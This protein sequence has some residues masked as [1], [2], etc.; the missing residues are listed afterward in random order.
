MRVSEET[1]YAGSRGDHIA[2]W[3]RV[4]LALTSRR[5]GLIARSRHSI[6]KCHR[7]LQPYT[8]RDPV[9]PPSLP[10]HQYSHHPAY[11]DY[12][13][14]RRCGEASEAWRPYGAIW[15]AGRGANIDVSLVEY[16]KMWEASVI[17]DRLMTTT[18]VVTFD[19]VNTAHRFILY[20]VQSSWHLVKELLGV[21]LRKKAEKMSKLSPGC[22]SSQ[23]TSK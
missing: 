15:L 6:D 13:L 7:C 4:W 9:A 17:S 12:T 8:S 11:S 19:I 5:L 22:S 21:Y 20:P 1:R 2:L 18:F 16:R 23:T 14:R 3:T 10:P